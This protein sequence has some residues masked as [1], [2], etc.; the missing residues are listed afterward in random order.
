MGEHVRPE[1]QGEQH[2]A[3]DQLEQAFPRKEEHGKRPEQVIVLL[4]GQRP[5]VPRPHRVPVEG[6]REVLQVC[7]VG[8]LLV[9]CRRLDGDE[10]G[11]YVIGEDEKEVVEREDPQRPAHV[12]ILEVAFLRLG[13]D[14]DPGDQKPRQDEE[15]VHTGLAEVGQFVNDR[16]RPF[17]R[18]ETVEEV[19][20]H[21]QQ[22]R[23]APDAVQVFVVGQLHVRGGGAGE[24]KVRGRGTGGP[25]REMYKEVERS[26]VIGMTRATARSSR[27]PRSRGQG[28]I[29][30]NAPLLRPS[31][32][33]HPVRP[34]SPCR[35]W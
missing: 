12:E 25:W 8:E 23:D 16:C 18:V 2:D 1:Q 7:Q 6:D 14:Q 13:M 31:N 30:L 17:H 35:R 19:K 11:K 15:E 29:A 34:C 32:A 21:D 33:R 26:T 24:F 22:R 27:C 5:E 20:D 4:H 3:Q 9:Q 10:V 28:R